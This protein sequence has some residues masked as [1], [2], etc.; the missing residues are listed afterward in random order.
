MDA[1]IRL[2]EAVIMGSMRWTLGVVFPSAAVQQELNAFQQEATAQAMHIHRQRDELWVEYT[3]RARKTVAIP[4]GPV[5]GHRCHCVLA[6]H[7]TQDPNGE[8]AARSHHSTIL[9]LS[10]DRM[11]A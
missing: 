9:E 8:L 11:V 6:V 3:Q 1:K 5:G 4:T 7:W 2:L 10:T